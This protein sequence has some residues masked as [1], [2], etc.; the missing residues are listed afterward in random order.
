MYHVYLLKLNHDIKQF[1]IGSTP[2]IQ[3]RIKQHQN[4]KVE[5]TKSKLPVK[6][7]YCEIYSDKDL[8]LM[9][10]KNLKKSGSTYMGL[11][12]RLKLK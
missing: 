6:L 12:K 1:Y 5:F 7:I 11:L 3:R 8:A 2:D 10:E 4:G 9:R